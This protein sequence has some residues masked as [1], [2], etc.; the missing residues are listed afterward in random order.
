MTINAPRHPESAQ[1][2]LT[3]LRELG[4][5]E[6]VS[7]LMLTFLHYSDKQMAILKEAA[8]GRDSEAVAR[9]A[10]TMKSSAQQLGAMELAAVCAAAEAA[11]HGGRDPEA[12]VAGAAAMQRELAAARPWM[13]ALA[14]G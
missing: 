8:A 4:G 7:T 3:M 9:I 11:G 6:L 2:A 1:A 10:H 14:T 12:A 13:E 5:D